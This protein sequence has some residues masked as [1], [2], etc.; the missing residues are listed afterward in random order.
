[1]FDPFDPRHANPVKRR[2]PREVLFDKKQWLDRIDRHFSRALD[3]LDWPEYVQSNWITNAVNECE[4]TN[5]PL[6]TIARNFPGAM[7]RLGYVK[8]VN[9]A[10]KDGRWEDCGERFV[11]YGKKGHGNADRAVLADALGW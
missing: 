2:K 3:S 4:D 7:E 10:T 1:M 8:V 11:V 5:L 6:N 9:P